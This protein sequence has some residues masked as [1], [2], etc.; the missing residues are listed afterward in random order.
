MCFSVLSCNMGLQLEAPPTLRRE[1]AMCRQRNTQIPSRA[2]AIPWRDDNTWIIEPSELGRILGLERALIATTRPSYHTSRFGGKEGDEGGG[3]GRGR[4]SGEEQRIR[5]RGGRTRGK[6][7]TSLLLL[8]TLPPPH[9]E[10]D[11]VMWKEGQGQGWKKW[12]ARRNS[13][14]AGFILHAG[15]LAPSDL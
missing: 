4:V 1:H 15:W 14:R 2:G 13:G 8:L 10:E 7:T 9:R 3:G 12:S 11:N 6:A 5:G